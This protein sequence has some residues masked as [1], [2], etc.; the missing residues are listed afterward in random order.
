MWPVTRAGC[1]ESRGCARLGEQVAHDQRRVAHHV[2]EHAAALQLAA[3][4]PRRV[5]A[6][7][8]LGRAGE[9]GPAGGRA[10]RAPRAA[11]AA[12]RPAARTPGSRGSRRQL[13]APHELDDALGLGD[14]ARRAASRRRCPRSVPAPRSIAST[15]SST[16]SMRAWL[17]PQSQMASM[18]GSATMS[19]IDAYGL[20]VADVELAARAAAAAAALRR[21]GAPDAAHVGVAHR[22][23]TPAGGSAAL[24]PL[25]MK[26]MPR[27]LESRVIVRPSSPP[28]SN[29]TRRRTSGGGPSNRGSARCR[30][31]DVP[32]ARGRGVVAS[33][34]QVA[35]RAKNARPPSDLGR[36]RQ[37]TDL[38]ADRRHFIRG[39]RREIAPVPELRLLVEPLQSPDHRRPVRLLHRIRRADPLVQELDDA[40]FGG[41]GESASAGMTRSRGPPRCAARLR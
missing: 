34:R 11:R 20:R 10:R 41:D 15:I 7:V 27:R 12:P 1:S 17:G 2:V 36:P 13:R 5:R 8:L 4:E 18:A 40:D 33:R 28:S 37:E 32:H 26:P 23:G 3:P 14:V 16:F 9:V 38:V 24:K 25:P 35:E 30:H 6:A 22:A 21:V 29:P 39:E 19:A 31:S